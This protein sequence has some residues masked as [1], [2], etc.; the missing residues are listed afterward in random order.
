MIKKVKFVL[1]F[2]LLCSFLTAFGN[3]PE[4]EHQNGTHETATQ[5]PHHDSATHTDAGHHEAAK[6]EYN[7]NEVV[8]HHI[9][10]AHS[11]E[12]FSIGSFHATLPLPVIL[13]SAEN[14]LDVFFSNSFAHKEGVHDHKAPAYYK[15]YI[16]HHEKI[17]LADAHGELQMDADHHATNAKPMDFSITKNVASMMLSALILCLIFITVA[18]AY[19]KKKQ[20]VPKGLQSFMEPIII[21]VRK[22]IV[23]PNMG[24]NTDRFMPYMLTLF[25]FIWVN[26]MLGLLPGSANVTGNIA[27]TFF[28][29][30][31]TLLATLIFAKKYYWGHIFNPPGVPKWLFPI[32]IPVE[33]VGIFTK[34]FALMIRLFANI[35]AGHILILSILGLIFMFSNSGTNVGMGFGVAIPSL[36]LTLFLYCIELLVAVLQAYIF[37]MLTA[38]FIGQAMEDHSH[39]AHDEEHAKAAH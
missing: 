6:E 23:E 18:R 11:W 32:M 1:S 38:L 14:G 7:A 19:T 35:T 13:Y 25:F 5:T 21:F 34:P 9:S 28:L 24:K 26:N 39:H 37:T 29:A 27:L 17:Y 31:V 30:L 36:L 16:L 15:N 22:D 33:I 8:M 20:M 10:D 4:H 2:V 12:F 3:Q